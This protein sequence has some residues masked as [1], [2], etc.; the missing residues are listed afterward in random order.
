M[1][2]V[3]LI[4]KFMWKMQRTTKVR[5]IILSDFEL[6]FQVLRWYEIV[7]KID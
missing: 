7:V 2:T 3:K 5:G 1:G 4:V 6:Y